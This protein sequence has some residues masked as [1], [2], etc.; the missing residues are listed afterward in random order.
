LRTLPG[1]N[2]VQALAQQLRKSVPPSSSRQ[3]SVHFGRRAVA[4]V[5][6]HANM[7]MVTQS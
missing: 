3:K 1:A 6:L 2:V 4:S 7:P 5:E